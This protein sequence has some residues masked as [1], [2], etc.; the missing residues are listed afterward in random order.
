MAHQIYF[1]GSVP[2]DN[3]ADVFR[4]LATTVGSSIPWLPD[5]ETGPDNWLMRFQRVFAEHPDFEPSDRTYQRV[6]EE[7]SNV[8]YRVKPGVAVEG[9]KFEN[10]P[11][12]RIA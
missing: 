9:L 8:Q 6:H 1:V 5:G 3:A 2:L 12:L 11:T 4:T 10:L 7:R